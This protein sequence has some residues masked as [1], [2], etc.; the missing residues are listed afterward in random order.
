MWERQLLQVQLF[1]SF[2]SGHAESA[3]LRG[4]TVSSSSS[5]SSTSPRCRSYCEDCLNIL[6]GGG[7]FDSLKL[8]DPWICFLCQPHRPHG[9]LVPREDWSI[10]VQELFA[11]NS[12]MAFVSRRTHLSVHT[13]RSCAALLTVCFLCRSRTVFTRPSPPTCADRFEFCHC[14]TAS[15]QVSPPTGARVG[16]L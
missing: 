8:L 11:N 4:L 1:T 12:A 13:H 5:S 3:L 9:A 2:R 6:V 7:T 15:G 16:C 14:S 10:R